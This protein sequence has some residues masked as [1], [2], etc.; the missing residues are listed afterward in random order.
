MKLRINRVFLKEMLANSSGGVLFSSHYSK[1]TSGSFIK[2][3]FARSLA[4]SAT[5]TLFLLPP[6]VVENGLPLPAYLLRLHHRK[7]PGLGRKKN[8]YKKKLAPHFYSVSGRGAPAGGCATLALPGFVKK[9]IFA[10]FMWQTNPRRL[11][12]IVCKNAGKPLMLACFLP[13]SLS[14]TPPLSCAGPCR[15]FSMKLIMLY[16]KTGFA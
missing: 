6:L 7:W 14:S 8:C 5:S 4:R 3:S 12:S 10:F 15:H 9:A 16:M 1:W 2:E 11:Y 13:L